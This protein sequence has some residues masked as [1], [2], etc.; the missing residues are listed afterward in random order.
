MHRK[1]QSG[2]PACPSPA[3]RR[4]HGAAASHTQRCRSLPSAY[5]SPQQGRDLVIDVALS[6]SE[7]MGAQLSATG[8]TEVCSH[9]QPPSSSQAALPPRRCVFLTLAPVNPSSSCSLKSD[10][11]SECHVNTIITSN[12]QKIKRERVLERPSHAFSCCRQA[13][14]GSGSMNYSG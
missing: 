10:P 1:E 12:S 4:D 3:P 8:N 5:L 2:G 14:W 9:A 6:S 7:Q 11:D 13:G